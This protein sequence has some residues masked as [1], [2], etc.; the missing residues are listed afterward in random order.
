MAPRPGWCRGSTPSTSCWSGGWSTC[1]TSSA[2]TATTPTR[3][4]CPANDATR[5]TGS[6]LRAGPDALRSG[7]VGAVATWL[8]AWER[9]LTPH[10]LRHFCASSLYARGMDLKAIQELLG[11]DWLSTTTRYIHVHAD[12]IEPAWSDA[13]QRVA[14]RLQEGT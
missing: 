3:R 2:T 7:L 9:R 11:H 14:A 12:H 13:N 5:D 10:G 6:C 8:P 4:C 1:A